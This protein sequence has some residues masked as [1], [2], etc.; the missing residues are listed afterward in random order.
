MD[1][2][3][4]VEKFSTDIKLKYSS[5]NTIQTYTGVVCV[6]LKNFSHLREPKEIT[7]EQIK[8][9]LL[10]AKT[11]NSRKHR[12]SALKLFYELT[13]GQPKKISNIPYPKGEKKLPIILSQIEIQKMFDVCQ[14][15][16]HKTI[17]ALLY[18]CGLRVSELINLRWEN[19]DRHRKVINIVNAK[20]NK[21]RQVM[22]DDSLIDLLIKYYRVHKTSRYILNGQKSEKYSAESIRSVV[23]QMAEK[24]GVS[25]RVYAHLIRHCAFTHMAENGTDINLIQR[26]AGHSDVR[27]TN[28]YLHLSTKHISKIQSPI[29][30][31]KL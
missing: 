3:K 22:L 26:I 21:D 11:V 7:C 1:Y 28:I 13:I 24:A 25:K 23:K 15:L 2:R 12:L 14:N 6:F 10:D 30:Q 18:S 27:T 8:S 5:E 4:W 19:I 29:S 17:L 16:K 9:W 20:G 31:I